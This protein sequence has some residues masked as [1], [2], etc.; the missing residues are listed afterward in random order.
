MRFEFDFLG[1]N[2]KRIKYKEKDPLNFMSCTTGW[3]KNILS[4]FLRSILKMY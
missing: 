1:N 2:I 4:G 3:R